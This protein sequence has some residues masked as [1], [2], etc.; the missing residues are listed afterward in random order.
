MNVQELF[1]RLLR[2]VIILLVAS[3]VALAGTRD[4]GTPDEKYLEFGKQFPSVVRLRAKVKCSN[5]DCPQKEHT[6][7]GSA[8]VIRPHWVLTAAHVVNN[9]FEQTVITAEGKE[10]PVARMVRHK[11]YEENRVGW[12]DLALCYSPEDFKLEFYTP[13]YTDQDELGKAITIAGFGSHGTFTTGVTQDSDG[14]RRAGHNVIESSADAVLFCKPTA[15]KGRMPLE[16]LIAPGDSGGGMFIGN[17]LAGIN[18]FLMHDDKT[19]NGN[20]ADEAAFVRVSLYR[21][22]VELQIQQQERELAAQAT[23]GPTPVADLDNSASK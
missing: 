6:Q 17:K 23:L 2:F 11:D 9:T 8:V 19:P 14:K 21:D 22:W 15:G 18:S 10:Y 3:R 7:L 1:A 4:P 12:H 16:F 5:P 20:Y 13:L